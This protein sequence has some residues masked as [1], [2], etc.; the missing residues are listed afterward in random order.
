ML[1]RS[2]VSEWR[3]HPVTE[4]VFKVLQED[5]DAYISAILS[6]EVIGTTADETA[7]NLAKIV[8]TVAGITQVFNIEGDVDE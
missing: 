2:E 4:K 1:T 6:G 5:V 3:L 8:G 7:Q